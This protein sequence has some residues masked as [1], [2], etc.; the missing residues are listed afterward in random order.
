M[1]VTKATEKDIEAL[2]Q[3][4][5]KEYVPSSRLAR[6]KKLNLTEH[7]KSIRGGGYYIPTKFGLKLLEP[8]IAEL[9]EHD[10]LIQENR[11]R[12]EQERDKIIH[13]LKD[14]G[15]V[16][17]NIYDVIMDTKY[18]SIEFVIAVAVRFYHQEQR[19]EV[20]G[21]RYTSGKPID[22][23]ALITEAQQAKIA[24][25]YLNAKLEAE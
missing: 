6:L 4:Y 17:A 24:R 23:D 19:Y 15:V 3:L 11:K 18:V 9:R 2:K 20:F 12:L 22:P 5:R 25:D 13:D 14:L 1:V 21:Y 8:F 16:I 7:I 10:R